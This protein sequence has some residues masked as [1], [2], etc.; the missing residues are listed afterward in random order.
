MYMPRLLD[1]NSKSAFKNVSKMFNLDYQV[2][3][4]TKKDLMNHLG[5]ETIDQAVREGVYIYNKEMEK[6]NALRE[7]EARIK[8]NEK[9]REKREEAR[10]RK[11]NI[12]IKTKVIELKD[13]DALY[14]FVKDAKENN[15]IMQ[16]RFILNDGEVIRDVNVNINL[17]LVDLWKIIRL[18]FQWDS[19]HDLFNVY[20]GKGNVNGDTRIG[21]MFINY[22]KVIVPNKKIVQAF[23]DGK[24]NC[25]MTPILNFI[26][27]KIETSKTKKTI[28]KYRTLIN[29]ATKLEE[30]YHDIGVNKDALIDI[31]NKLQMDLHINLPFQKDFM[32]AK[33]SK[34]PLRTFHFVNT[35]LNHVDFDE[36]THNEV[37]EIVTFDRL[38]EI[39][40]ELGNSYYTYKK[41]GKN[42]CQIDTINRRYK[43]NNDFKDAVYEFEKETGLINAKICSIRDKNL[44]EFVRQSNHFNESVELF[45]RE[46]EEISKVI[47]FDN[48]LDMQKAYINYKLCKYYKGFLGK[49]TDFRKCDHIV[50]VGIY[51]IKN[52]VLHGRLKE[53]NKS[54][55][56]YND[57]V[58]I[59]P[60]LEMLTFEGCTY[61]IVAG[62]WG[63]RL[64]FDFSD[65]LINK[66][67][68]N[69]IKSN[70]L[71]NKI[72]YFAKY[73]G[74]CFCQNETSSYFMKTNK[75]MVQHLA[76][77]LDGTVDMIN[78]EA[79]ISYKKTSNFCL[80]QVSSFIT[81]YM[82]MNMIEQLF[83]LDMKNV[84]KIVTD[85]IYFNGK[86]PTL[87]NCFKIKEAVWVHNPCGDSYISNNTCEQDF[88]CGD[89]KDHHMV[90]VHIGA[91]GCGKTHINLTDKGYIGLGYFAPSWKLAHSKHQEYGCHV[92]TIAK[93]ISDDPETINMIKKINNNL[94]VDEVSMLSDE[95]KTKI[96]TNFKGCKIIFCGDVGFQ[97]PC[98]N[99]D[100]KI[101]KTPFKL[102]GMKIIEYTKNHRVQC[103]QLG[104]LL[105]EMR[106]HIKDN[107]NPR[108]LVERCV[109]GNL[110]DY[111][112]VEDLI[113]TQT[114][115]EKD[116]YT[117]RFKH[118][119]KYYITKSDR[120]YGRGEIV[121]KKPDTEHYKIQHAF[122][123]HSIQ[124]E[125]A[126]GKLYIDFQKMYN[127]Q[128]LYTAVSRAKYINQIILI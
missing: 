97:L 118:L 59:S 66:Q 6:K 8:R 28:D 10:I 69:G 99:D 52:I 110:N 50:D 24:M 126:T 74:Q 39:Q 109:K 79:R 115:A 64:D 17:K 45:E 26:T 107:K 63:D 55:N 54:L 102:D 117:E 32:V 42:I 84:L 81:A 38:K 83:E 94:I 123:V 49:V 3:I 113:L 91:G 44:C 43:L 48:H 2:P 60:E 96:L 75:D 40:N 5:A 53:L 85:G 46:F 116:I 77:E 108:Y 119:E 56:C 92:N 93:L 4:R 65:D 76:N 127:P 30:T 47:D 121:F 14:P 19:E 41:N 73:V 1:Y 128:M 106:E 58:Y 18:A 22:G 98:F 37:E 15:K 100:P 82:R 122:T 105:R 11:E 80:P 27:M 101:K 103:E 70:G 61:D 25:V 33:S 125:T 29:K 62:C 13:I 16:I 34:K 88:I 111:N 89:Y 35:R 124:G 120:I 57:N 68:E 78:D 104:E 67:D 71:P 7:E 31:S 95:E 23:F 12:E 72:K 112:Y 87:K 36:M 9:A 21:K 51:Q 86:C 20:D 90:E 114:H